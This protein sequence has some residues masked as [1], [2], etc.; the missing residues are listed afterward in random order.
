MLFV[1]LDL[2]VVLF[3]LKTRAVLESLRAYQ[4][5]TS[6]FADS[7]LFVSFLQDKDSAFRGSTLSRG[8]VFDLSL[9]HHVVQLSGLVTARLDVT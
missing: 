4:Q 8:A 6:R 2:I 9:G 3:V 1:F 5:Q 7:L